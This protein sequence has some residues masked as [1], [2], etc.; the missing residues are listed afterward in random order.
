MDLNKTP[1]NYLFTAPVLTVSRVPYYPVLKQKEIITCTVKEADST[2]YSLKVY[3]GNNTGSLGSF[4][5]EMGICSVSD[6]APEG[7]NASCGNGTN[8]ESSSTKS[9]ILEII[10]VKHVDIT[11]WWCVIGNVNS[12]KI[13]F[14]VKGK[15]DT[16]LFIVYGE[17][18][19]EIK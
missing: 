14:R 3:R 1:N 10:R 13:K 7:Y 5:Q 18:I 15:N 2:S 6:I 11:Y 16:I 9:Y 17:N 19:H 4:Q 12:N 8:A